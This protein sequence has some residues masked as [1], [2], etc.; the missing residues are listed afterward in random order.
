MNELLLKIWKCIT[1]IRFIRFNLKR[2]V[3]PCVKLSH[4]NITLIYKGKSL[5]YKIFDKQNQTTPIATSKQINPIL[6]E[7]QKAKAK[8]KP[9]K[10][11]PWRKRC[12]TKNK[13]IAA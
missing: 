8:Q 11:H 2:L 13:Q 9:K 4:E 12:V 1:T 6:E 7:I 10:N 5:P 3:T